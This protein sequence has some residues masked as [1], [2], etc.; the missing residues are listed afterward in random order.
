VK[1]DSFLSVAVIALLGTLLWSA[2]GGGREVPMQAWE[3]KTL[4]MTVSGS[5]VTL[6]ED[7]EPTSGTPVTRAPELGAKGWE[8]VSVSGV[9]DTKGQ[10]TPTTFLYVYWFKRPK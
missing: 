1:H 10:G 6:Y 9:A 5:K 7:G 2:A 4:S 8:L 3:Y